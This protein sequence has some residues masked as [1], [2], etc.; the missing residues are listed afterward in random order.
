MVKITLLDAVSSQYSFP[1]SLAAIRCLIAFGRVEKCI[2][3]SK[4][5]ENT[6][7]SRF[8]KALPGKSLDQR[9]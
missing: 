8:I 9:A 1:F 6:L 7:Q 5:S 3:Q 2:V 4:R